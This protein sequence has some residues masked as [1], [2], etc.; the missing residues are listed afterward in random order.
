MASDEQKL[1]E[2]RELVQ[3]IRDRV[4]TRYPETSASVGE[5]ITVPLADLMPVVHARDAA[6]G[7]AAAIGAVN[8]RRGGLANHAIQFTKRTVSRGLNW[9]VRD[10]VV[11]NQSVITCVETLMEAVNDLNRSLVSLGIQI[12]ERMEQDRHAAEPALAELH[13]RANQITADSYA[14]RQQMA[15][16]PGKW[17]QHVRDTQIRV[18]TAAALAEQRALAAEKHEREVLEAQHRDF[19]KALELSV[20]KIQQQLWQDMERIRLEFERVIHS[21]LRTVRQRGLMAAVSPSPQLSLDYPAFSTRFR[22]SAE[23]VKSGQQFYAERFRGA[24]EVIDLGC[25]NGEFLEVMHGAQIAARGVDASA[26]SVAACKSRS[27]E[28]EQADM[29]QWLADQPDKSLGGIFCSQVVEHLPPARV[30]E[31]VH[32]CAAKLER[33]AL[34]V[35]ETP[36]PECLAI[37]ATH[38]YLDPTHTRPVPHPLL[39]FYLQE[40]GMGAIEVVKR[41][42]AADSW[43]ELNQLPPEVRD[44]FFGGLDYAIFGRKL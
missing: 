23:H 10:Q 21:E 6:Q 32:L 8:P 12:G 31:L 3:G 24:R 26:E 34:L 1:E 9:F 40:S 2:L 19:S 29:F 41:F 38:F 18:D 4:R 25:G 16:L 20:N 27:L 35:F 5:A 36:N 7:K 11:F 44:R 42:P 30:S 37:F 33:N 22:G 14:L 28:A 13:A 39:A 43:P 15:P 17:D